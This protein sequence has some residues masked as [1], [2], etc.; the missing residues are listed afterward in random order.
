ML[1]LRKERAED[2]VEQD[3]QRI[4][5]V[6]GK[7]AAERREIQLEDLLVPIV[8]YGDDAAVLIQD[9]LRA[10]EV[11]VLLETVIAE[12]FHVEVG[13]ELAHA[14]P[15][16]VE[17]GTGTD[18]RV[19][20]GIA[21]DLAIRPAIRDVVGRSADQHVAVRREVEHFIML[22][23]E[24]KELTGQHFLIDVIAQLG[25]DKVPVAR[26]VLRQV[27]GG[28]QIAQ[29]GVQKRPIRTGDV[30]LD[31][32]GEHVVFFGLRQ[33]LRTDLPV[34]ER[35][36]QT[37]GGSHGVFIALRERVQRLRVGK[38][39]IQ[40]VPEL[41]SDVIDADAENAQ[42]FFDHRAANRPRLQTQQ[43]TQYHVAFRARVIGGEIRDR[44]G[45]GLEDRRVDRHIIPQQIIGG[46]HVDKALFGRARGEHAQDLEHVVGFILHREIVGFGDG[47][48]PGIGKGFEAFVERFLIARD[49][50]VFGQLIVILPVDPVDV[51]DRKDFAAEPLRFG[52]LIFQRGERQLRARAEIAG[53]VGEQ[54]VVQMLVVRVPTHIGG[55]AF[56]FVGGEH[57]GQVGH[58]H[59]RKGVNQ[60]VRVFVAH[61]ERDLFVPVFSAPA[62]QQLQTD[63]GSRQQPRRL[64]DH[65][66]GN[67]REKLR[68][69]RK[70]RAVEHI[71]TRDDADIGLRGRFAQRFDLPEVGNV[72]DG[73]DAALDPV[74]DLVFDRVAAEQHQHLVLPQQRLIHRIERVGDQVVVERIVVQHALALQ[75][76]DGGTDVVVVD[77]QSVAQLMAHVRG[78]RRDRGIFVRFEPFHDLVVGRGT[79]QRVVDH[80]VFRQQ[81]IA[82]QRA[83]RF[84]QQGVIDRLVG[85]VFLTDDGLQVFAP[86]DALEVE[87]HFSHKDHAEH[88]IEHGAQILLQ[89]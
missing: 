79:G 55:R 77:L 89:I 60:A 17:N 81:F 13:E 28:T 6:V 48:A 8:S 43:H 24:R 1:V 19:P 29:N 85:V 35:E 80:G 37:V 16:D 20:E 58:Q 21:A 42:L 52:N 45:I 32:S 15:V 4:A 14:H 64:D 67:L 30:G 83:Q 56:V 87:I 41:L 38:A 78:E 50:G 84:A 5:H 18:S 36:R 62:D 25:A 75:Q 47:R 57:F 61:A 23:A 40:R 7:A 3:R 39:P 46:D 86:A 33:D 51:R 66:V 54:A 69:S 65:A 26:F 53:N 72:R 71:G 59:M 76:I 70:D 88:G 74:D 73:A 22:A 63:L 27:S 2:F 34:G 44:L 12:R 49:A 31:V 82:E 10:D 9:L 11:A 68:V